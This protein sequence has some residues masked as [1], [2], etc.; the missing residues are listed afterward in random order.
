MRNLWTRAHTWLWTRGRFHSGGNASANT[1]VDV[2]VVFRVNLSDTVA[3]WPTTFRIT[4]SGFEVF[5]PA[6]FSSCL[7]LFRC[8]SLCTRFGFF[9][10]VTVCHHSKYEA[11]VFYPRCRDWN[12]IGMLTWME[13]VYSKRGNGSEAF[14]SNPIAACSACA[15]THQNITMPKSSNSRRDDAVNSQLYMSNYHDTKP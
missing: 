2:Y 13:D 7:F 6:Y 10:K 1:M 4:N 11:P 5:F 14:V 12:S 9:S 15:S 8:I 3:L